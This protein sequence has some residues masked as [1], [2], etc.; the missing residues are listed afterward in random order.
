MLSSMLIASAVAFAGSPPLKCTAGFNSPVTGPSTGGGASCIS[1]LVQAAVTSNNIRLL[2]T[3]PGDQLSATETIQEL[4]QANPRS[5]LGDV[6]PIRG[7]YNIYA[8]LCL[9]SNPSTARS[10]RTVQFL[11]HG[12][13]SDS[14]YWDIAPG[15]SY[16]DAAA[17]AGYATL[18]YDRIGVGQSEHPDPVQ[19]VQGPIQVE[20]AHFLVTQLRKGAFGG[21]LFKNFIGVGHSAGS[22]VTQGQTTKYPKDFDA[23]I[24]TG[25][26]NVATYIAP[27]LASFNLIIAN[28][29]PSGKFRGIA[30]G[31]LTP[32]NQEGIQF[33]FFRY[34]YF[35]P[36]RK[37]PVTQRP[38]IAN[39]K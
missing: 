6:N 18:S 9:P 31:Y 34:P 12:D 32:A 2:Y 13:T 5:I 36:R 30:N 8:K 21:Y 24:L 3:G 29:D 33:S 14:T 39:Q 25:I 17:K 35:D 37:C 7:T 15:Y 26:S 4:L 20:I 23:V 28:T 22:T 38:G 1:G 19:V 16:V 11:T 27:S 10:V